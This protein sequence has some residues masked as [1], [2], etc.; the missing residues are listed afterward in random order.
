MAKIGVDFGSTNTCAAVFWEGRVRMIE[1]SGSGITS[2]PSVVTIVDQDAFTGAEAVEK[3]RQFPDYDFRNFKRNLAVKINRDE[4]MA[5]QTCE[6]PGGVIA[7]RGPGGF[8]YT[9]VELA[10]YILGEVIAAANEFLAPNDT[11]TGAVL[12]VPATFEPQQIEALKE[13]ARLAGLTDVSTIEE[14]V[15]A[16]LATGVD[17]RKKTWRPFIVDFGGGTLDTSILSLGDG[18]ASVF[19]KNGI[20]DL[21]G[22]D[23]DKRIA[24]Y[25]VNLWLTEH[26]KD[27]RQRDAAMSRIMVEAEAVKKRLSDRERTTFRLDSID[28]TPDGVS[29]HMIYEIDR[30]VFNELTRDLQERMLDACK[31]TL[32]D[33]KLKDPNF[34]L[35]DIHDVLL[36]GGM[37]RV[38]V[39]REQ[40]AAF[41]GKA[42]RKDE[43]PEQIVAQ[44]CAIKAAILEGRLPDIDVSDITS[45]DIAIETANNI[46]AIVVPRGTNFPLQKTITIANAEDGQS[47]LSVRLLYATRSRAEDC[48]ILQ[49]EDIAIEPGPAETV[50]LK[51]VISIDEDC[52]PSFGR[53][54]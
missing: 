39:I 10:S 5:F 25:V 1:M 37:T 46:P 48:Q 12:G 38:P 6:G 15:A 54:A 32:D 7:Y 49:A 4:D 47:E 34:S 29:L 18:K 17:R 23:F 50:K 2:I 8:V 26:Q 31:A 51:L 21:G 11:V 33:A 30:K 13:A 41:F 36:V 35:R 45:H 19:A 28:R 22:V 42:P 40:I 52:Q 9:P 16:A 27:L 43:N 24:D 44:G 14:P 53:A 3:G 20:A